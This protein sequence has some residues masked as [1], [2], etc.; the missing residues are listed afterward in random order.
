MQDSSRYAVGI[1]IGTT[2][3]RC[4]IGHLDAT[5]GA[6]TIVGVSEVANTGMRKGSI[7]NLNGPAQAI[8]DALGEAERMSGYEVD[9][10]SISIN[11]SHILSTTTDGMV[12]VGAVDHVVTDED[13]ARL[14]EV[15][16]VGKVPANRE[17]LAVVPHT[18]R[19]D[20]QDNI[21]D[22]VGM[23]G[24]RLEINANVISALT[25]HVS[26]LQSALD[27]AKVQT[28]V[29]TPSV[30]AAAKA[31]LTEQ[32]LENGVAVIDFGAATTGIAIFEEGDLQFTSVVPIGSNNITND[33]AIGLKTDPE[34]A[35]EVKV[36]HGSATPE[37]GSE[38]VSVKQD[39]DVLEFA[40][41]DVDEIIGARL[42]ELFELIVK[43]LKRAGRH[44]KLPSG[45]VLVGGGAKLKNMVDYTK[46]SLGLAVR[47]GKA[48]GLGG[49][50]E[51]MSEPQFAVAAGLMLIDADS[52]PAKVKSSG[53]AKASAG[54]A[55]G[56]L[57]KLF[58][59][60]KT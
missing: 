45:V 60:L 32:Q 29:M 27:L 40:R 48:K 16:T 31:V 57:K 25:P 2:K 42:E 18:Y 6:P 4:V 35:E 46:N 21:K 47:L 37:N 12:A 14:E 7:V 44:A 56:M 3:V 9:A 23:N 52:T 55:G 51:H 54:Q 36:L 58:G 53:R 19:L 59:R 49:V 38:T 8:D 17:I 26:A 24:T 33:L 50:A 34:V 10:A 5:T 39:K 13:V 11:G 22:P 15:A 43:E 20:G 28:N 30:V 1:D 41:S